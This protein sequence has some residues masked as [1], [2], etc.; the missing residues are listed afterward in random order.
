[1]PLAEKL[2]LL[3]VAAALGELTAVESG[4]LVDSALEAVPGYVRQEVGR[5]VP[6]LARGE[7]GPR[8]RGGGWQRERLFA[9]VTE[10]L[11]T[12]GARCAVCVVV[13]DVHWADAST[14][15]CL[16]F[17]S[18]AR[19][20][21]AVTLVVTCRSDEAPLDRP[22]ADW[23]AHVRGSGRVEEIRLVPL[24]E[25]ES[26]QLVAQLLG[27]PPP[28]RVAGQ[29]YARA[30]GNPFFTE[31]LAAAMRAGA[32]EGGLPGRLAELLAART[33]RCGGDARAVL[34]ALAVAG[35]PLPEDLLSDVSGL[36]VEVA[37]RGL[38]ELAGARLLADATA[39][40]AHRPRHA[41]LAEAVTAGL[42]PG[43]R[44]VLH[45]R[46]ARA[47]AA[48]GDPALAAEVAGHW[49]AAGRLA[50][51]LPSRVAAAEAAEQVFGYA[52]AAGH[53]QRA[54][55]LW[56]EVP[57]AAALAGTGLP[58]LYVR[59]IGAAELSGDTP[60][61][62]VLAEDAYRRFADDPDPA[63][64]AVICYRAGYLRGLH[65][66]DA[67]LPLLERAL[68]LFVL[69]S[70]SAEHAE[71]LFQYA[72]VLLLNNGRWEDIQAAR[73]RALEIAEA[74]GATGLILRILARI[75]PGPPRPSSV[76]EAFAA[77]H[78][79]WAAAEVAGDDAALVEVGVFESD[80]LLKLAEFARAE[81]VA[82]RALGAARRAGLGSW[83]YT[84]TLVA[85][86][87]EAMWS[88]GRT[89]EA[90]VLVDPLTTGPPRGDDWFVHLTRAFLDMLRGD[91]AAAAARQQ[92]VSALTGHHSSVNAVREAT[93][94]TVEVALWAGRP[95]DALQQAQ[96][97]LAPY[98]DVP[99]QAANCGQLLAAG[100][101]AC[102]DLA[103]QARARRDPDA[104]QAARAAAA[105]LASW[106]E[107]M[108]GVPFTDNPLLAQIP[109][110]RATWQAEWT[111]LTGVSDPGAW[112]TAAKTWD[113]LGCPHRAGY[114]WWRHAQAQLDAGQPP[115]AATAAVRVAAAAAGGHA[116][117]HAQ[118][119]TLAQR[120]NIRLDAPATTATAPP[121]DQ[122]PALYGLTERE[123]AVLRL[124]AAGRTNTQIGAELYISAT[125]ARV[126]V[127]NILRKLG[128]TSRVQAAAVAERADLLGSELR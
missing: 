10:L 71:A 122:A 27:A 45:E 105:E 58:Q 114:A 34:A 77:F 128:V 24:S 42:L 30:E 36:D 26:A 93:Q 80:T 52:Q 115:T 46:T 6:R 51:E 20:L 17:L 104:D 101:R 123:L 121:P 50:E 88:M 61:A 76:R 73:T 11:S 43:E 96:Q 116:P 7:I 31:Q 86:A 67:G 120:A 109:A 29:L 81:E 28:A 72:R 119:R 118:V 64:A 66:A 25:E 48:A 74:A 112:H 54:I 5:L 60:Q 83:L 4:A 69:G 33:G 40:G 103:E 23:L 62:G 90:A 78:R 47:L 102:A 35:R 117:L 100:L 99:D 111:R 94:L 124:L 113:S 22:V 95:G 32:A 70:P 68:E 16:T 125:T 87:A 44:A 75:P 108:E 126:H 92:Q 19:G 39:G 21:G 8:E 110:D 79:A 9:A 85:N 38:R 2:P 1:L 12:V 15:D 84:V 57:G 55:E 82:L 49:Q 59:A 98:Q 63:I 127:S 97:A 107:Q 37:R 13:E 53:W 41:L 91:H 56:P 18:Q 65:D 14:L 89:A 106:L 3:P